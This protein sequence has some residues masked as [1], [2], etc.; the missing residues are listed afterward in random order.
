MRKFRTAAAVA[1]LV[2]GL[3]MAGAGTAFAGNGPS[4]LVEFE[5]EN[6]ATC[7]Q[8]V[9]QKSESLIGDINVGLGV[10]VFGEGEGEAYSDRSVDLECEIDQENELD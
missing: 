3:G 4:P 6:G 1:A 7:K 5:Q 10:G 9:K 8:S 2:A